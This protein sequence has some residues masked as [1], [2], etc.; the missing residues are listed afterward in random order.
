MRHTGLACS[1]IVDD[2]FSIDSTAFGT[3]LA[4]QA[5]P[6]R[7]LLET[8]VC[9]RGKGGYCLTGEMPVGHAV[10]GTECFHY[11]TPGYRQRAILSEPCRLTL[12]LTLTLFQGI[13]RKSEEWVKPAAPSPRKTNPAGCLP[14]SVSDKTQT[15]N[16]IP[17]F[18][19]ILILGVHSFSIIFNHRPFQ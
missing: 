6:L 19:V 2:T 7:T 9:Y 16:A 13:M 3:Q 4:C 18:P 17:M 5:V 8:Q 12:A 10:S 1:W 15:S 14:Y 11:P